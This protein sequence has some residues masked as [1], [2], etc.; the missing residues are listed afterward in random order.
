[1]FLWLVKNETLFFETINQKRDL[2]I[3]SSLAFRELWIQLRNNKK[4]RFGN[5][6]R[7]FLKQ[8]IDINQTLIQLSGVQDISRSDISGSNFKSIV[9]GIIFSLF[10]SI[11][12]EWNCLIRICLRGNKYLSSKKWHFDFLLLGHRLSI[13]DAKNQR[14]LSKS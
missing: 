10:D 13:Y 6:N 7:Q 5:N 8:W 3:F 11:I 4:V 2:R 1:M 14:L 9:Y 12:S